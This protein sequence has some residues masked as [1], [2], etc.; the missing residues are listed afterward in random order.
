MIQKII[1]VQIMDKNRFLVLLQNESLKDTSIP[2]GTVIAHL[3][4]ADMVTEV[5]SPKSETPPK[6]DASL[7]DFN[8]LILE[9]CPFQM[10]GKND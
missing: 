10:G 4:V 1:H 6:T 7:F 2:M 3:H 9:I 5:P 8:C